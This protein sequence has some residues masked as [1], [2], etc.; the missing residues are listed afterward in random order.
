MRFHI[1][2]VGESLL[3]VTPDGTVFG[4]FLVARSDFSETAVLGG[5]VSLT[6]TGSREVHATH[7]AV[8]TTGLH[9]DDIDRLGW[10]G[11]VDDGD[12][13]KSTSAHVELEEVSLFEAIESDTVELGSVSGNGF[14]VPFLGFLVSGGTEKSSPGVTELEVETGRLGFSDSTLVG[15]LVHPDFVEVTSDVFFVAL[16]EVLSTGTFSRGG[17]KV[18]TVVSRV[19]DHLHVTP[20]GTVG[21]LG[22]VTRL[23]ADDSAPRLGT[24]GLDLGG[25]GVEFTGHRAVEASCGLGDNFLELARSVFTGSLGVEVESEFVHAS[26]NGDD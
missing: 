13:S 22:L 12:S 18:G 7:G 11:N 20:D 2:T 6:D 8:E 17:N 3:H 14:G 9:D 1:R 16:T 4:L 10:W 25:L 21:S 24:D 5:L 26:I 23:D 15:R 19:V